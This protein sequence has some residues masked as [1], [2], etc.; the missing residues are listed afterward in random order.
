MDTII[1]LEKLEKYGGIDNM[2][3]IIYNDCYG[4]FRPLFNNAAID[5]YKIYIDQ[6]YNN[7]TAFIKTLQKH[8][9]DCTSKK[10][11][12]FGL[13]LCDKK[14]KEYVRIFCYDGLESPYIDYN[15]YIIDNTLK[16]FN[17]SDSFVE[18]FDQLVNPVD[19]VMLYL[20]IFDGGVVNI[21]E[22]YSTENGNDAIYTCSCYSTENRNDVIYT[23]SCSNF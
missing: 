2:Y 10:G 20:I 12:A 6:K 14:Y 22:N 18:N 9:V 16:I 21:D 23:C 15:K 8:G 13:A 5:S 3:L 11:T 4:G 19:N 17:E 1:G 7:N